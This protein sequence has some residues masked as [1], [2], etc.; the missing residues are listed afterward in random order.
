MTELSNKVRIHPTWPPDADLCA[1]HHLPR[2]TYHHLP[3]DAYHHLLG[4]S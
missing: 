4:D 1:Y 2:D 3:Q